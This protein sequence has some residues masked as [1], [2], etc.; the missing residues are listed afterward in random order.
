MS[1]P[2]PAQNSYLTTIGVS[3]KAGYLL[4]ADREELLAAQLDKVRGVLG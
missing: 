3:I 2:Y 1:C 4:A